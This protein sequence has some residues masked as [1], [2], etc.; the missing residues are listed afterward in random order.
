M[1]LLAHTKLRRRSESRN[2]V[3]LP[4]LKMFQHPQMFGSVTKD[5]GRYE[6]AKTCSFLD[7]DLKIFRALVLDGKIG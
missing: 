4:V 1:V 2:F 7:C 5:M 6:F 3:V